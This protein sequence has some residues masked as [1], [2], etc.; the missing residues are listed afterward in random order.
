[1]KRLDSPLVKL[2]G[3]SIVDQAMLSAANF[4]VGLILIRYTHDAQYGY[5]VLAFN[6]MMLATTLQGTFVGTPLVIRL[7]TLDHEQ[8]RH[9]VGSLMRDQFRW[10]MVGSVLTLGGAALAWTQGWLDRA[11]AP[12]FLAGMV[13]I[14]CALYREYFR[15]VLLMYQ[16]TVSV[17]AADAVYVLCLV[18]GVLLATRFPHAAAAA[19]LTGAAASLV[20]AALLRRSLGADIDPK[21]AHG[22]L[23]DIARMGAWAAA[24]GVIYWMFT[25]G[26]T[27]LAAATL[28]IQGVAALAASR[29]LLMPINLLSSGVQKQLVPI[30]SGWVHDL[31]VGP[32]LQRLWLFSG[33]L[34]M[35]TLIYGVVI[36]VL[37]DWIFIDL[38]RKS[39]E[40]RDALLALWCTI[41][42]VMVVRDPITQLLVLRQRFRV[43]MMVSLVCAVLALSIS[44]VGML[45]LGTRGALLGILVGEIANLVAVVWL[46]RVEARAPAPPAS[47]H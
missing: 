29:L 2:F 17:L 21:A 13:L 32:T 43:L 44:Y 28:D 31:G 3:S 24:G 8:R 19:L 15:S 20:G 47:S 18:A 26:Y 23:A 1:M 33:V 6:A 36:W 46:A 25:Q 16:R 42:L 45:Y 39:F 9:W 34:A 12:V 38:M 30:A 5:Y 37:R 7:P 40:Q 22:R 41:F 11:S 4:V 10:A 27:F 14:L 35:T